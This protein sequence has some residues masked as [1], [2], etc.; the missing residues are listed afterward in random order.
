MYDIC[1]ASQPQF[2]T[3]SPSVVPL[4][5]IDAQAILC[6]YRITDTLLYNP[7]LQMVTSLQNKSGQGTQERPGSKS[8][9]K[10]C[11]D[12]DLTQE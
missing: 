10:V 11:W 7:C 3:M 9:Y 6:L 8:M 5:K 1:C 12:I 2:C 4:V